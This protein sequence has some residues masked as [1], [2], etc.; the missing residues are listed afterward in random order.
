MSKNDISQIITLCNFITQTK[1]KQCK[2][3]TIEDVINFFKQYKKYSILMYSKKLDLDE[4]SPIDFCNYIHKNFNPVKLKVVNNFDKNLYITSDL[5][6]TELQ[7]NYK[8]NELLLFNEIVESFNNYNIDSNYNILLNFLKKITKI[9]LQKSDNIITKYYCAQV[10]LYNYILTNNKLFNIIKNYKPDVFE[11]KSLELVEYQNEFMKNLEYIKDY[12][13]KNIENN[14]EM[15][16]DTSKIDYPN[17]TEYTFL[18]LDNIYN[19]INK[20]SLNFNNNLSYK[21]ILNKIL[22]FQHKSVLNFNSKLNP[23][24]Y[25]IN[26]EFPKEIRICLK[27]KFKTILDVDSIKTI[28]NASWC[29][30][31]YY[32]ALK[33]YSNENLVE[34]NDTQTHEEFKQKISKIFEIL[35]TQII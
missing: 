4:K 29:K 20:F 18:N 34:I 5:S 15:P 13:I 1:F 27:D 16:L 7:L 24:K 2:F 25:I 32:M 22:L 26:C 9:S 28:E 6:K 35:D 12:D 19:L 33:L 10:L 11:Q 8:K 17:Y 31:L 23:N 14:L 3:D 21:N 30:T